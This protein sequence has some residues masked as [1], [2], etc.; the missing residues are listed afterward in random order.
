M[1]DAEWFDCTD[2]APMLEFL[3]G[4]A[5]DRKLRLFSCACCGRLDYA[6]AAQV[7]AS[8]WCEEW[9]QLSRSILDAWERRLE[10]Q[11]TDAETDAAE[12][13]ANSCCMSLNLDLMPT[14]LASLNAA[15]LRERP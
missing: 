4:K 1:T 13:R 9:D 3:R 7:A 14:N 6:L 10:G 5:S 2:P 8:S 11:A 12:R 15:Y